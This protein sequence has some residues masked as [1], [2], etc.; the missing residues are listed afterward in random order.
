MY[1]GISTETIYN[2]LYG[3]IR[4]Q[5]I[6]GGAY[7]EFYRGFACHKRGDEATNSEAKQKEYE[8]SIEHYTK[9]IGLKPDLA[10]A[11]N[12]RGVAYTDKGDYNRAIDD[13]NKAIDLNHGYADAHFN[14]GRVHQNKGDYNHAIED[15]TK[16]IDLKPDFAIAY[17]NRGVTFL[18]NNAAHQAIEDYTTAIRLNPELALPYYNRGAAYLL[19]KKWEKARVDLIAARDMGL[20][21]IASFHDD[22]KSVPDFEQKNGLKLPAD[23]AEMLTPQ[24]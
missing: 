1:H 17:N 9:A 16:A 15:Y 24:Q 3:F 22:Y 11:Y 8:K 23:I 2:D 5:D 10:E 13:C 18:S 20:D 14:R 12:N 4:N 21:I 19:L 7:T 6:H